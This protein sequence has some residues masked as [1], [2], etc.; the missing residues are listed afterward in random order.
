MIGRMVHGAHQAQQAPG[1][2]CSLSTNRAVAEISAGLGRHA[3]HALA[4]GARHASGHAG[5]AEVFAGCGVLEAGAGGG[6]AAGG[7][8]LC[9]VAHLAILDALGPTGKVGGRRGLASM[10]GLMR[11]RHPAAPNRERLAGWRHSRATGQV[12]VADVA[13]SAARQAANLAGGT[14]SNTCWC[15]PEEWEARRH[16]GR[17]VGG[18]EAGRQALPPPTQPASHS[19]AGHPS[20]KQAQAGI[21][22]GPQVRLSA[23][24]TEPSVQQGR[25]PAA[26]VH[27]AP[28][29]R[30]LR[31]RWGGVRWYGIGRHVT[32]HKLSLQPLLQPCA[33]YPLHAE[34]PHVSQVVAPG[35]PTH[36]ATGSQHASPPMRH[37]SLVAT[38]VGLPG[39]EARG[40]GWVCVCSTAPCCMPGPLQAGPAHVSTQMVPWQDWVPA[41]QAVLH[42]AWG[43]GADQAGGPGQ[44]CARLRAHMHDT[45]ASV[46]A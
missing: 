3:A 15:G 19:P 34:L 30:Q 43:E 6:L 10:R 16:A 24:H 11:C 25:A 42:C 27:V 38:Q 35:V 29:A 32:A 18:G 9:G 45:H 26:T 7:A 36:W 8:A 21:T 17:V 23:L 2:A 46:H 4:L 40:A 22:H 44:P 39:K 31:S 41:A 14:I 13:V 5:R 12:G 1:G 37:G 20:P 28:S 33:R